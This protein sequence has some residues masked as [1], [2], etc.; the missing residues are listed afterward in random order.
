METFQ[1]GVPKLG[2]VS[3]KTIHHLGPGI[4]WHPLEGAAKNDNHDNGDKK[5]KN[6][7]DLVSMCVSLL[8]MG[9]LQSR[10][11]LFRKTL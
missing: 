6:D 7:S 10:I 1:F 2:P 11:H 9:Y 8:L 4:N 3:L 5:K